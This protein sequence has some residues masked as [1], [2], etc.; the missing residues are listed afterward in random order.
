MLGKGRKRDPTGIWLIL[1]HRHAFLLPRVGAL[2]Y[3]IVS[4]EGV[5]LSLNNL[6]KKIG[7][8]CLTRKLALGF[9]LL[10]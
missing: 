8:G 4:E 3:D 9:Q 10:L 2:R 7:N 5:R 1:P 6:S